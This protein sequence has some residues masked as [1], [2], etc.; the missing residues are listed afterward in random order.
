MWGLSVVFL[1]KSLLEPPF[2]S[3]AESSMQHFSIKTVF[4]V[5]IT[6]AQRVGA[7]KAFMPRLSYVSVLRNK[8]DLR[9]HS[10]FIL[11]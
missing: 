4:F 9:S 2:E 11:R 8:V 7:L 10:K 1:K 3:L 6:S 5:A